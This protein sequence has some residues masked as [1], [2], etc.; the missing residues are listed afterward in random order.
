[1]KKL[2]IWY[3]LSLKASLKRPFLWAIFLL[4][5][6]IPFVLASTVTS[7]KENKD[8]L[9]YIPED[10]ACGEEI[11][12]NLD[13][14]DSVM[15][16]I[17]A[18]SP[19]GLIQDVQDGKADTG[20]IFSEDF[21]QKVANAETSALISV[22]TSAYSSKT[23]VARETVF[24]AY[25]TCASEIL[26][27]KEA[28]KHFPDSDPAYSHM[29]ELYEKYRESELFN[30][31]FETHQTGAAAVPNESA[32]DPQTLYPIHG[33]CALI[34]F[35]LLLLG[36]SPG[37]GSGITGIRQGLRSSERF[38]FSLISNLAEISVPGILFIVL[39]DILEPLHGIAI[40]LRLLIW[41]GFLLYAAVWAAGFTMLYKSKLTYHSWMM[42]ILGINLVLCPII[43]DPA[44]L[45]PGLKLIGYLLPVGAMLNTLL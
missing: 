8:I 20:F 30:I 16:F 14:M 38:A 22:V 34:L 4:A 43:W 42:T 5:S 40:P 31:V 26:L 39:S 17:R 33:V 13:E 15:R 37:N 1:M 25:Y 21:D 7:I 9:L 28:E 29:T 18:S 32:P 6:V 2:F 19:D 10:S 27:K 35:M 3:Y 41:L 11:L 44:M 12:A 24:A 36:N 45:H 23:A